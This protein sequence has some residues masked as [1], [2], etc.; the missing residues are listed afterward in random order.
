MCLQSLTELP[1]SWDEVEKKGQYVNVEVQVRGASGATVEHA[2]H[3]RLW[4]K[5]V[6]SNVGNVVL[7]VHGIGSYSYHFTLL[8]PFLVS[9]GFT[10]VAPDQ[11][12]RGHTRLLPNGHQSHTAAAYV[13]LLRAFMAAIHATEPARVLGHSMGGAVA[14]AYAEA[15]S[16]KV[17]SLALFAPA[18]MMPPGP[19]PVLRCCCACWWQWPCCFACLSCINGCSEPQAFKDDFVDYQT[20]E[21]YPFTVAHQTLFKQN[22]PDYPKGF[23]GAVMEFPL[24]TLVPTVDRFV[25]S[26]WQ[27]NVLLMWGA[28]DKVVPTAGF[29]QWKAKLAGLPGKLTATM[30]ADSGH[31]FFLEKVQETNEV[32]REWIQGTLVGGKK[33]INSV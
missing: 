28:A 12:G 32:V 30:L 9:L 18:G 7:L 27:G 10:V 1:S 14:L 20:A 26:G 29:E 19:I 17:A 2:V 31:G 25:G 11:Y 8:A 15:Q 33:T 24:A 21:G 5:P 6:A 16:S 22:N 13:E 3:Y 4:G 23:F